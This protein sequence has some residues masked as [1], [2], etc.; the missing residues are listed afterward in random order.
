M[1]VLARLAQEGDLALHVRFESRPGK[2]LPTDRVSEVRENLTE[3][4]L[5]QDLVVEERSPDE[6]A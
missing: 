3:L 1:K 6:S 5:A 2:G 4:G